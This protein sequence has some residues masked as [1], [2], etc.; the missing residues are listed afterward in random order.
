VKLW[1]FPRCERVAVAVREEFAIDF[2]GEIDGKSSQIDR[3][4]SKGGIEQ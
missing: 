1:V 2:L 4:S 3:L